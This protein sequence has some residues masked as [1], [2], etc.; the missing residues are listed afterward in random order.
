MD[1]TDTL[2]EVLRS[3]GLR[4]LAT[5]ARTIGDLAVAEDALSEATITALDAW[6]KTGIPDNPRAWLAVVARRKALV[7]PLGQGDRRVPVG[8]RGR[9]EPDRGGD[10]GDGARDLSARRYAAPDL[11][12]LPPGAWP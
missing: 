3:E 6:P 12:L 11:H 5:L 10:R 7:S 4:V 9:A 2:V 1:A 8:N